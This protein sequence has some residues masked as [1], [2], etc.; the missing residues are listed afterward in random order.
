MKEAIVNKIIPFSSVDGPG[1]R[2]AIF[3]QGCN[4]NC[5]YCHNPETIKSCVGCGQ[6]VEACPVKALTLSEGNVIWNKEICVNCD[7]CVKTCKKLSTPKTQKMNVQQ[8]IAEIE[9]Y[10]PFISGITT[11]GGECTLQEEFLIELFREAKKKGLTCFIDSNGSNLFSEMQE[12]LSLTDKVMLDV[13]AWDSE[14]HKKYIGADN[15]NVLD[16]LDYLLKEDKMYE[17]RTV[18]VPDILDNEETIQKVSKKIAELNPKVR[19][20][21]IKFRPLG[22]RE[23]IKNCPSPSVEYMEAL[24]D[25]CISNG[26]E[27][28]VI[29]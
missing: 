7:T 10:E 29:V 21:L 20:K 24:K 14:E 17:V 25:I 23:D 3:L 5:I 4:F 11:S 27:N 12:L 16:N 2:T 15:K 6:C 13:K 19:Y 26:C 9:K 28:V 8:V 22:V 18:V 1:N